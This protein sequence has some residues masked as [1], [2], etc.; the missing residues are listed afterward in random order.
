MA[1]QSN[2]ISL[3]KRFSYFGE[4]KDSIYRPRINGWRAKMIGEKNDE[5][6]LILFERR[7]HGLC[8]FKLIVF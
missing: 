6:G 7:A 5:G 2:I 8:F 4:G 3:H 1:S